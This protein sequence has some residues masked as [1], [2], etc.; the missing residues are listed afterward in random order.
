M[1]YLKVTCRK[2]SSITVTGHTDHLGADAY[3]QIL[4]Q[5]GAATIRDYL[6]A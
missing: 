3:N 4:S 2:V 6:V 5:V 1:A